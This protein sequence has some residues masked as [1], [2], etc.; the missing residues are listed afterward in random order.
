MSESAPSKKRDA[1][2]R[3]ANSAFQVWENRTQLVKNELA[4]ASAANDAKTARLKAL[5]LEK[6]KQDAEE[7]AA[8]PAPAPVKKRTSV[9]RIKVD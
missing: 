2:L 6:E 3:T 8:N 1:A 4:A 9:K 7:A 5:R